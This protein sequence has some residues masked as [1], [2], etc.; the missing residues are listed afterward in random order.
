MTAERVEAAIE[1]IGRK[2]SEL[3]NWAR[4]AADSLTAGEGEEVISQA[5]LQNYLWYYLPKKS[6]EDVW[7]PVAEGS[8]ALLDE[9]DLRRYAA[10]A[11][12]ETTSDVLSAWRAGRETGFRRFKSAMKAS[13]VEPLDTALLVWGPVMGTAEV[14]ALSHVERSLEAA[15]LAGELKPGAKG[16]K[17]VAQ[18]VCERAIQEAIPEVPTQSW[19]TLVVTE[20][21]EQWADTPRSERLRSWRRSIANSVLTA[22]EPPED[23]G[24]VI[25]AMRW[26]LETCRQGVDLTQAGYLP[27]RLV[28]EGIERFFSSDTIGNPRSEADVHQL[29][30]LREAASHIG[31]LTRRRRLLKTSS[32]GLRLLGDPVA[33]WCAIATN[34]DEGHVYSKMLSELIAARLLQGPAVGLGAL[35]DAI[36]PIL[37]EQGWRA[38]GD[39]LT[40]QHVQE[41]IHR[42]LWFWRLFGLLDEVHPRWE[43]GHPVGEY[44]TSLTQA[45]RATAMALIHARA[46]APR[47]NLGGG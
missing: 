40:E 31:A 25:A 44:V 14:S 12:S 6:D 2:D 37:L 17:Q 46:T 19:L 38:D 13:G 39:P 15:I 45:G 34:L 21:V 28:A 4:W 16:S 30:T 22:P 18:D 35:P 26:L 32:A 3:G 43:D 11:R 41:S 8:A 10:I 23:L 29:H 20:R 47:E 9:L 24:G 42:P 1:V 27:P 36:A 5:S 7:E 33:M